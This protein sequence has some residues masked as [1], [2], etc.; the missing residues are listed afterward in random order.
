MPRKPLKPRTEPPYRIKDL[1]EQTG[2]SRE[3]IRFYIN[4]GLLPPPEKSA[5]NM[6]WYGQVHLDQLQQIKRLQ[7]DH[8]LSLKAIR[9]VLGGAGDPE[10]TPTQLASLQRIRQRLSAT[11]GRLSMSEPPEKLALDFG[12][13]RLERKELRDL[14]VAASGV[15]TI[16]DVEIVKLWISL[17]D[18]GLT[19]DRGFSPK[20]IGH[21]LEA[22]RHVLD[23]E[24]EIFR[25]RMRGL[26]IQELIAIIDTAIPAISKLFVTMHERAV[27]QFI[28][29]LLERSVQAPAS[30]QA[31]RGAGPHGPAIH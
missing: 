17:R 23:N 21:V 30:Q 28:D 2:V 11:Q 16:S 7:R 1:V 5:R 19:L 13:S 4:E 26:D 20:D 6:A 29:D 27:Y 12:L 18:A 15:A 10:F 25:D 3:A 9:M 22:A 8:F 24:L 14:G 31:Q